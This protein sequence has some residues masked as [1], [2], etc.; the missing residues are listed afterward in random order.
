MGG[1]TPGLVHTQIIHGRQRRD[2]RS[3]APEHRYSTEDENRT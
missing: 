3:R 2:H 1:T